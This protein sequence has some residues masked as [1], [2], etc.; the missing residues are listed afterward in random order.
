MSQSHQVH[1]DRQENGGGQGL[2]GGTF[3][4][5]GDRVSLSP[6]KRSS[7]DG[8]RCWLYNVN[9]RNAAELY[10]KNWV[11]WHIFCY[12]YLTTIYFKISCFFL[13]FFGHAHS[14]QKFQGQELNSPHSSD[15][16][17]SFTDRLPENCFVV[18]GGV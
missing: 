18:G 16:S 2:A 9:V 6:E 4:F 14:M 7:G 8:W 15:H 12:A 13:F 1:R 3:V 11:K 5:N 17:E 10:P